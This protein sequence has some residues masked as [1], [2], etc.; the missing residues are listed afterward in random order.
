MGIIQFI[1]RYFVPSPEELTRVRQTQKRRVLLVM[2]RQYYKDGEGDM[3]FWDVLR[4][5]REEKY[6]STEIFVEVLSELVVGRLIQ[7]LD[8]GD[9]TLPSQKAHYVISS[10]GLSCLRFS[11]T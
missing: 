8:G 7:R 10:A 5:F 1:K 11:D 3:S 6:V 9:K 2:A 4:A